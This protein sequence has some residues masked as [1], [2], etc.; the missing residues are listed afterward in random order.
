[1]AQKSVAQESKGYTLNSAGGPLNPTVT[2][3]SQAPQPKKKG[4]GGFGIVLLIAAVA[5]GAY[6]FLGKGSEN[7]VAEKPVQPTDVVEKPVERPVEKP[8]A[9]PV[10]KPAQTTVKEETPAPVAEPKKMTMAEKAAAASTASSASAPQADV[11]AQGMEAYKN[12]NYKEA[13]DLFKKAA[14]AGNAE[15]CY[16][17]GLMLSTGKGTIAK[18]TLQA[19]VW[20][21]KAAGL[22]HAE[23]QKVLETL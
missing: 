4:K 9:K 15:A 19:K 13:H 8:A 6:L 5:V 21:K 10:E 3:F 12:G 17:L 1:V 7:D 20:M 23:A 11:Y 16:Q 2:S 22:G 18:N 14:T